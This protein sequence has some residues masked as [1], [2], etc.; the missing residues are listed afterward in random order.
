MRSKRTSSKRANKSLADKRRCM[1]KCSVASSMSVAGMPMIISSGKPCLRF[2]VDTGSNNNY[3][4]DF[5]YN[6]LKEIDSQNI[7]PT[8]NIS[9][10]FGVG[11]NGKEMFGV[12]FKIHFFGKKHVD[13]FGVTPAVDMMNKFQEC[14]GIQF[15]GILG[16]PFLTKHG[17]VVDFKDCTIKVRK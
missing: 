8:K 1:A 5:T 15:H 10:V 9:T 11:D 17:W 16:T 14:C 3:L 2:L 7:K 6:T 13:D 12:K 4:F